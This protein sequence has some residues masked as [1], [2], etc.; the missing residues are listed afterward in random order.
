MSLRLQYRLSASIARQSDDESVFRSVKPLN[1]RAEFHLKELL[2]N[3][4]HYRIVPIAPPNL[5]IKNLNINR[6]LL[7]FS[8]SYQPVEAV[9]GEPHRL[10][11]I[12]PDKT[13]LFK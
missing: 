13:S 1:Q 6:Y 8:R 9:I 4:W 11:A 3:P 12:L 10:K 2:L 7:S 5:I